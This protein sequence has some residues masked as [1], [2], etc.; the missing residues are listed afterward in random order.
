MPRNT[1]VTTRFSKPVSVALSGALVAGLSLAGA[2]S[3]WAD[4]PMGEEVEWSSGTYDGRNS[5]FECALGLDVASDE[6]DP[7]FAEL[8]ETAGVFSVDVA[9]GLPIRINADISLAILGCKYQPITLTN[10]AAFDLTVSKMTF[11]SISSDYDKIYGGIV[12]Q[13]GVSID[14]IMVPAGDSVTVSFWVGNRAASATQG[15]GYWQLDPL[16]PIYITKY[17][18]SAVLG[19]PND[20]TQLSG[21]DLANLDLNRERVPGVEYTAILLEGF[22]NFWGMLKY[23]DEE[24]TEE[25]AELASMVADEYG[26]DVWAFLTDFWAEWGDPLGSFPITAARLNELIEHEGMPLIARGVTDANGELALGL[27]YGDMYL[28][29]ESAVPP[30]VIPSMPFIVGRPLGQT[31]PDYAYPKNETVKLVKAIIDPNDCA[32]PL[33]SSAPATLALDADPMNCAAIPMDSFGHNTPP[34]SKVGDEIWYRLVL[35][36]P[37]MGGGSLANYDVFAII[38]ELDAD[39]DLVEGSERLSFA[40]NPADVAAFNDLGWENYDFENSTGDYFLFPIEAEADELAIFGS[41]RNASHGLAFSVVVPDGVHQLYAL[42]S[43]STAGPLQFVITFAATAKFPGVYT[44]KAFY[45]VGGNALPSNEVTVA[46]GGVSVW[47]YDLKQAISD[48]YGDSAAT[49]ESTL[50]G[51]AEFPNAIGLDDAVFEVRQA[52]GGVCVGDPIMF[53]APTEHKDNSLSSYLHPST[54]G[55][56]HQVEHKGY[57]TVGGLAYGDYCL[58]EK[59]APSGYALSNVPIVIRIDS[60]VDSAY[61]ASA[62]THLLVANLPRN[63]GFPFPITG[64]SSSMIYAVIAGLIIG[65]TLY[66]IRRQKHPAT[67]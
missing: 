62:A 21:P 17:A 36:M 50:A 55:W 42:R 32:D 63:A 59:T 35:D 9:S 44:N 13:S 1:R 65:G 58:I 25:I 45:L 15:G 22:P 56:T 23:G 43:A 52:V 61:F 8:T 19:L 48:G 24:P 57:L 12:N 49:V 34:L 47:K 33:N 37:T 29:Y 51:L 54:E 53:H 14:T 67:P 20:G 26:G 41:Y 66:V 39:L 5:V 46:Y 16:M 38:D 6:D 4:W 27:P 28:I 40:G 3:A 2:T 64:G 30:G 10:S 11:G 18:G 7:R 31:E 60:Q